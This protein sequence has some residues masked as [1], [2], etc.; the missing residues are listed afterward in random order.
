MFSRE[1]Q[2]HSK[3]N[4]PGTD[5]GYIAGLIAHDITTFSAGTGVAA[6]AFILTGTSLQGYSSS[7]L[8]IMLARNS[9][10]GRKGNISSSGFETIEPSG[11]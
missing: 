9:S 1:F 6:G 5:D 8:T 11:F 3:T 10:R 7:G 4:D 2:T